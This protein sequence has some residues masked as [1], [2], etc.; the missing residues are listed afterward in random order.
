MS[1]KP[2]AKTTT[3]PNAAAIWKATARDGFT[4]TLPSGLE[5]TMRTFHLHEYLVRGK[6]PETLQGVA[7]SLF[8]EGVTAVTAQNALENI[9]FIDFVIMQ[10]LIDPVPKDSDENVQ[11]NEIYIHHIP[12]GDRLNIFI[13]ALGNITDIVE[14]FAPFSGATT[15]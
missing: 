4:T 12:A 8:N 3:R 6:F 13:K 1:R 10:C 9:Q 15:P 11:D 2:K 5:V 7:L 14:Q